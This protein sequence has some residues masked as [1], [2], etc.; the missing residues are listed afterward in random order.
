MDELFKKISS[1]N[2]FNYLLP[3][4]LFAFLVTKL[5][6][7][8]LVQDD[9]L[10]GAF[11]Y[12]FLGVVVSHAASI[13]IGPILKGTRFAP[14]ESYKD[15]L[16]AAKIDETIP[17]LSQERGTV[18]SFL[19]AILMVAVLKLYSDPMSICSSTEIYAM[20]LILL[21]IFLFAYRRQT[22]YICQ[23]V[24]NA[25]QSKTATYT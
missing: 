9:L 17:V 15:Y 19:M 25:L 18:R 22:S 14:Q 4:V 23:R 3:G 11:L 2:I 10:T 12:Y 5:T 20:F 21:V 7:Y 13:T 1:Y 6:P 8:T 24:R 16:A